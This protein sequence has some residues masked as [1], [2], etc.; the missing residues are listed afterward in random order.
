MSGHVRS[1]CFGVGYSCISFTLIVSLVQQR[2]GCSLPCCSRASMLTAQVKQME[3]NTHFDLKIF[4]S[5][6]GKLVLSEK[7]N[8]D[9]EGEANI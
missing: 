1:Y 5:P 7:T 8:R 9:E 6:T 3:V 4:I 2:F